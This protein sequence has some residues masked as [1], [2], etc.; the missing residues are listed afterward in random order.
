MSVTVVPDISEQIVEEPASLD[1]SAATSPITAESSA[2]TSARN[3]KPPKSLTNGNGNATIRGGQRRS[4]PI[5]RGNSTGP[6]ATRKKGNQ[7]QLASSGAQAASPS[8]SGDSTPRAEIELGQNARSGQS[9]AN[10]VRTVSNNQRSRSAAEGD[11]QAEDAL[12]GTPAIK[13]DVSNQGDQ[14]GMAGLKKDADADVVSLVSHSASAAEAAVSTITPAAAHL[15]S[16]LD[17][18]RASSAATQARL[19]AEL[20]DLRSRN[21]DEDSVRAELKIRTKA[22]EEG[23]RSAESARLEAER[24]L[25]TARGNKK[26]IEDRVGK[27]KT[28]LGKLE[29]REREIQERL[30]KA[31]SEREEKLNKLREEVKSR[32]GVLAKEEEATLRLE[33]RVHALE[34]EI[35]DR[36]L[37]LNSMREDQ[38]NAVVAAH[39]QQQ[40][41]QQLQLQQQQREQM[42]HA[43]G[44]PSSSASAG[45]RNR[46]GSGRHPN[47]ATPVLFNS[48]T[49]SSSNSSSSVPPGLAPSNAARQG[50][51]STSSQN[52]S[53]LFDSHGLAPP[54]TQGH[55]MFPFPDETPLRPPTPSKTPPGLAN[56]AS[57]ANSTST[58]GSTSFLDHRANKGPTTANPAS[59]LYRRMHMGEDSGSSRIFGNGEAHQES[60]DEENPRRGSGGFGSFAPFGPASP[61]PSDTSNA[62]ATSPQLGQGKNSQASTG[63]GYFSNAAG[64]AV[65]GGGIASPRKDSPGYSVPGLISP[66]TRSAAGSER[67]V[68]PDGP[69]ASLATSGAGYG[70][71]SPMTPHQ[72]SLIPSQLFDLL[73]DV[74]MPASPS[75]ALSSSHGS[76]SGS[77]FP[78]HARVAENGSPP[79]GG[80]NRQFSSNSG[81]SGPWG[82]IG[83]DEFDF[84]KPLGGYYSGFGTGTGSGGVS[85]RASARNNNNAGSGGVQPSAYS[86]LL[87]DGSS[88]TFGTS[89]SI[90][91]L[92]HGH[93]GG[94]LGSIGT[95]SSSTGSISPSLA[96]A[97]QGNGLGSAPGSG[98]LSPNDILLLE[99]ARH[100]ALALNP[101]AKAF[102][103]NRPLP[104]S[105]SSSSLGAK[106]PRMAFDAGAAAAG[107]PGQ[108]PTW[109]SPLL[110]NRGAPTGVGQ[111]QSQQQNRSASNPTAGSS[112]SPFDDDE[113]LKRW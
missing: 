17:D 11:E 79:I 2:S 26:A 16:Q 46:A 101:D 51:S 42:H 19:E 90:F 74:E 57:S 96:S 83:V 14:L 56:R 67:Q 99:K 8:A 60:R 85:R 111:G 95:R 50:L 27:T 75:P 25:I 103:F 49:T 69:S 63:D 76:N 73:D 18:L 15:Q 105:G 53:G 78:K 112:F 35:E 82:D 106:D 44:G 12:N 22:L 43:A 20:S 72:A 23:K 87:G 104:S 102:S 88:G 52:L 109:A 81:G 86:P 55:P 77:H 31:R 40:Q 36:K 32:E 37:E 6:N 45:Q 58:L 100:A 54:S 93:H 62:T 13:L 70:P 33:D 92:G 48:S 61:A 10:H 39:Q 84:D 28:E 59:A 41:Q 47:A 34:V 89:D 1:S 3:A 110:G 5:P 97:G 91:S 24:K 94:S 38:A 64:T 68:I 65:S 107:I 66:P 98:K 29:K 80:H 108:N 30:I 4:S 113:L 7:H 21:K 71:L 9:S